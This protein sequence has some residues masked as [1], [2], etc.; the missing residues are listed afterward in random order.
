M[1]IPACRAISDESS[2]GGGDMMPLSAITEEH[3]DRIFATKD[4]KGRPLGS[5]FWHVLVR[6]CLFD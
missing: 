3:V 4:K 5:P 2:S 6:P 1:P